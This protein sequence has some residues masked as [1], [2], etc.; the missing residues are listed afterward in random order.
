MSKKLILGLTVAVSIGIGTYALGHMS[1]GYG[2]Y[3]RMHGGP[4]MYQGYYGGPGDDYRANLNDEDIKVGGGA[5][6]F[7]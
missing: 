5:L 6:C 4:G 3:D 2:N 1:G 7:H